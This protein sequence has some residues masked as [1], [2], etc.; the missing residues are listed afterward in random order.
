[1]NKGTQTNHRTVNIQTNEWHHTA[2]VRDSTGIKIYLDGELFLS[3]ATSPTEAY[4]PTNNNPRIGDYSDNYVTGAGYISNFRVVKGTA[5]YTSNFTVPTEPLTAIPGTV[6]LTLQDATLQD[7]SASS[8]SMSTN[9]N[10]TITEIS[11]FG[12]ALIDRAG[13]IFSDGYYDYLRA[14]SGSVSDFVFGTGDFTVEAWVY[15]TGP[16]GHL[17]DLR[18]SSNLFSAGYG[19][20]TG[21]I[22][23]TGPSVWDAAGS[24]YELQVSTPL[25]KYAWT[26]VAYVRKSQVLKIYVNGVEA[27]SASATRN[28]TDGGGI[29]MAN[30]NTVYYS[31]NTETTDGYVSDLRVIKGTALYTSNFTPPTA[32]LQ[33][34][35]NTVLLLNGNNGG[36]EDSL[37]KVNLF[38]NGPAPQINTTVKKFG[39][40]SVKFDG[41][42]DWLLIKHDA[43]FNIESGDFTIEGWY[44]RIGTGRHSI[45]NKRPSSGNSGFELRIEPSSVNNNP[46]FYFT[47]GSSFGTI[48][49]SMPSNQW[50]Y[51]AVVRSG[52]N[53]ALFVDGQRKASSS[54]WADGT[55]NTESLRLG[56]SPHNSNDYLNGYL[57]DFRLTKGVARYNPTL[58]THTV[59][60]TTHPTI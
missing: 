1:M 9:G 25:T 5:V 40:G 36:V 39:T 23:T 15:R 7:N 11:P 55:S 33:P 57:D 50:V 19:F 14:G 51:I 13:S 10:A 20:N 52:S 44:Y 26:H 6:L 22:T 4:T 12:T 48:N 59:P 58:T 29:I 21:N 42:N 54:S 31:Q 32:P 28:L 17:F 35:T 41:S 45:L 56:N 2:L 16:N 49:Y 46:V 60:T 3:Y 27:G 34:I 18:S 30:A 53:A 8:H 43:G 24:S 38:T 37:G 47:G